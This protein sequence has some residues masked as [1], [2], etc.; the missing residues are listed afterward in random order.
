M[1]PEPIA[2][3]PHPVP[4]LPGGGER[5]RRSGAL[6]YWLSLVLLGCLV[7][8]SHVRAAQYDELLPSPVAAAL[9]AADI[10]QSAISLVV[11]EA[12]STTPRVSV[13]AAQP[14][15]PASVMKLVTT[16]AAL[17]LLGPAYT[18]RTEAY[19]SGALSEGVLAG[20][21][22]LKGYGDPKLTFEG[23]WLLLRRL[24]ARGIREIRGELV[25]DRSHFEPLVHDSGAFDGEPLRPY[26]VGPDAMLINFKSVSFLF[27]PD[28]ARGKVDVIAQPA[29]AQLDVLNLL[30]L[31]GG[32][33]H[34]LRAMLRPD[35]TYN[36]PN[37]RIV[38]TGTY[39]ESC[40][41]KTWS[42]GLLDHPQYA[43]GLFRQLWQELGGTVSG[44][45]REGK[46][47]VEA[48]LLASS[49]SPSL[50]EV[51]RDI[52]KFSNNVMAR[53]LLLTLGAES[54]K[55][56]ARPEDGERA[57]RQWLTQK[58]LSMPELVL[59]NGSG[60]SRRERISGG[61]L[62]RLLQAAYRSAVMPEFIASMPLVAVDGTM[63]KRLN[64][65]PVAGN[66]HIK[67]GSLEGVSTMAGYVLDVKG[68][69]Q[70]VV[71]LV[72]HA[73]AGA[74]RAAHDALLQWVYAG[75]S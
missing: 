7:V 3:C 58:G 17:E 44:G 61:S 40:G 43:H 16:Y 39:P 25:L 19:G 35:I 65:R 55:R 12:G 50:S 45:M 31:G 73:N 51:M 38:F 75:G 22:Y 5:V 26:N 57:V 23:F 36:G 72:N 37:A 2:E 71:F 34:D 52:N 70:V 63:R 24:Y 59:E 27:L 29:L 30:K 13:N 69:Q 56:P 67:G 14:M 74:A 4:P 48:R 46:V 42:L 60:L 49:E 66:A 53:Q 20:D 33:C 41:E 1:M 21:L 64:D 8:S 28:S 6:R 32:P 62:A 54:A 9:K 10:P 11:Q 15:N 68:K 18:W 47:P